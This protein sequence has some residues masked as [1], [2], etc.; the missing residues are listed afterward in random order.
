MGNLATTLNTIDWN[1]LR[2][3]GLKHLQAMAGHIWTDF[4]LHDPGVT[5]LELLCYAIT[6][7]NAR[8]GHEIGALLA[9][10]QTEMAGKRFFSPREILT[11]NPVTV[12]DYRK[13]LIDLPGVK[14]A[15]LLPVSETKPALYYDRD[16]ST[17]LYDYAPGAERIVLKGLYRVLIEKDED[18]TDEEHLKEAVLTRLHAHRNLGEDFVEVKIMDVETISVFSDIEIE[19]N[20]DPNEV[21]GKIY[22]DL[23][24]FISPRVR[25]YSLKRML[26]KGKTIEEIFTG[27]RLENGFIDDAELGTGEKRKELHASDLIRIIMAHP[28]VK[29][30]KNLYMANKPN[31]EFRE[32]QEWA[33]VVDD[34]KALVM[35]AFNGSKLRIFKNGKLCPVDASAVEREVA[36][37]KQEKNRE[38]FDDPAMDLAEPLREAPEGLWT[39]SPL[40]YKLP[41]T[42][43][44][45]ET[46]LPST[47]SEERRAQAKQLRAYLLF[48]EQVLVNYLKQ[49]ASFK[50]LF[51]FRQNR[52]EL[53]KTYFTQLLPEELWK[54]D[55]PEIEEIITNDPTEKLPLSEGAFKRKNRILN[56]LLAQFN[57]KFADYVFFGFKYKMGESLEPGQKERAYLEAKADFLENYPELSYNRNRACNYW[58]PAEELRPVD[59][60]KR[61]IAAKLGIELANGGPIDF[62]TSEEFYIVEH[63]LFRPDASLPL[64][65]LCAEK[66]NEAQQPD[67]YSYRLTFVLPKSAGRF[68]NSRFK[69]L[70][71]T[72][73]ANETPAHLSY[74]V[75]ELNA[76]EM[77]RF[78]STYH[79][80]LREVARHRQEKSA[81]FYLDRKELLELLGIG[82]PGLPLL[83]LDA[84]DVFGDGTRPAPE[85]LIPEWKDLSAN[86]HHA[87][88]ATAPASPR[89]LQPRPEAPGFLRFT[90]KTCLKIDYPL[91]Q[92]DFSL[93]VVFKAGTPPTGGGQQE[94]YY[95]LIAGLGAAGEHFSLGFTNTGK[96]RAEVGGEAVVIEAETGS[97]HLAVLTREQKTGALRLFLDGVVQTSLQTAGRGP[98]A[99]AQVV[100]GPGTVCDLAEVVIVDGVLTGSRKQRLERYLS[101]KWE[102]PLSG[103]S[104]IATPAFHLAADDLASI[105]LDDATRQ[106]SAWRDLSQGRKVVVPQDEKLSPVY[107]G[108]GIGG[109]PALDFNRA[110]LVIPNEAREF[111][112]ADFT[113]GF[114]Y[115]ATAGN[116][117]LLDGRSQTEEVETG[118][119]IGLAADGTLEVK[120]QTGAVQLAADLNEAH[121]AVLTGQS[122]AE[123][124][125]LVTHWLDGKFHAEQ[126]FT[127]PEFFRA[128]P[129]NLTIGQSR[130]G[131][132]AFCGKLG[133]VIIYNQALSDWERQR[134]EEF[135]AEKWQL[136]LTGVEP[137][138]PSVLH[139]DATRLASV[140]DESGRPAEDGEKIEQWLDWGNSDRH[141]V[142]EN[143]YRRPEYVWDGI[144]GLPAIKFSQEQIDEEDYYED[145][146]SIDRVIQNDFTMMVVF[147]PDPQWYAEHDQLDSI[148][149]DTP[150]TDGVPLLDADCSGRYNDF[151]L[152][153]GVTGGKMVLMGGI[154]DR[155]TQD[156]TI[157]SRELALGPPHLATFSREKATGEVKLY[158][159]GLLHAQADLRD[160]VTLNDS[161]SIRI[162]AFNSEGKAFRGLIGEIILFDQ[163][164]TE[165][166]RRRIEEYLSKKWRISLVTLPVDETGLNFHLDATVLAGIAKDEQNKVRQ[167]SDLNPSR[168]FAAVYPE[169]GTPSPI[170]S[171]PL[172]VAEGISGKPALHFNNSLM[173]IAPEPLSSGAFT[174]ALVC[175]AVNAGN[176]VSDWDE[177]G[178]FDH[179]DPDATRNFGLAVTKNNTLRFRLGRQQIETAFAMNVPHIVMI[180]GEPA[181]GKVQLYIDGLLAAEGMG[182]PHF[183]PE[184]IKEFTIG[185]MRKSPDEQGSRGYFYGHLGEVLMFNRVLSERQRQDLEEHL[186]LKWRIDLT[187]VNRIGK[188]VLHLDASRLAT[189]MVD[190]SGRVA[191]WRDVN[192]RSNPALQNKADYRP[193]YQKNAEN[194]LGVIH[195]AGEQYLTL[196][197]V[198]HDDFAVV[199]VY[200][201]EKGA[202][203][204]YMPV[205]VDSFTV[206][207]GDEAGLAELIWTALKS[208]G[209]LDEQGNVLPAFQPDADNFTLGLDSTVV[210]GLQR[211]LAG[212][213]TRV[214]TENQKQQRT[215]P[216]DGLTGIGGVDAELS[217]AIWSHLVKEGYIN[218]NG[219]V[220]RADYTPEGKEEFLRFLAEELVI[221]VVLAESWL[222]GAGIFDGNCPGDRGQPN[223]RD[224][225]ILVGKDGKLLVGIGVPDEQD[226]Q[227][228]QEAS[229][230]QWHI[231]ILTR[232]KETGLVRLYVD[233]A[234]P[235]E[236]RIAHKIS[237]K[238]SKRFTIGAVNTGGN[239]FTGDLGEI[240]VLDQVPAEQELA[241]LRDYLARKWRVVLQAEM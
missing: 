135:L 125:L 194:G 200:R 123:G 213:I 27:P 154:G 24:E 107:D 79:R 134:L 148:D 203:H 185:A 236:K 150:W 117:C 170:D 42:Y 189:V 179:Y 103:V 237:L 187:G 110:G 55:F 156:H 36:R 145:Y 60:L 153:F 35:E 53:L 46:G 2:E 223:K 5:I 77:Q 126:K 47:V 43:G 13:L 232:M 29:E 211:I 91:E 119:A 147:Q 112:Q 159:D 207:T 177:A 164:L 183:V 127:D 132:Q 218:E 231:A 74:N 37:L 130:K 217:E 173:T 139:L 157:K 78:L 122:T 61:L 151:G 197:P 75:L 16:N 191:Q 121:L 143:D 192:G 33:L 67:P 228:A 93:A 17:L 220:L 54:K 208:R 41:A 141:A 184:E 166:Q 111:F 196:N 186:S 90:A 146:L 142:Q 1:G 234:G 64:D 31:P 195:F 11:I 21:M 9:E 172:Y 62:N 133:E 105:V 233:A 206:L 56:H 58:T 34:T 140:L 92:D 129:P 69:E 168:G 193:L 175:Q 160:D 85:S 59:G 137:V 163:V 50:Q 128:C 101:R 115:Q 239:Y 230:G 204:A 82:R 3:E 52:A 222:A 219:R 169:T 49:L 70:V 89:Y 6:D 51:A 209:Y 66:I 144:N 201:A 240:I 215:I 73:I 7:L 152:S 171:P 221:K 32:K 226:Y 136:D 87:V 229:F 199:L 65:F 124:H 57:E 165:G 118:F 97:P 8:L 25:Q 210:D 39:Y 40:T 102:I 28:A 216:V 45:S 95:K 26:Q 14:N 76:G 22:F 225:G 19:A 162:A 96:I 116:G 38:I 181:G 81:Q 149:S 198:V 131:D 176:M 212:E 99:V 83:H 30:V 88:A 188:P 4:G 10:E 113:I 71:Y 15:W 44:V 190:G 241:A 94:E 68:S 108:K 205:A 48:F 109:L 120:G 214:L 20:A 138:A 12:N 202:D 158:V 23:A 98:L 238:D 104:S 80:F 106:V 86:G 100:L 114:V 72:T 155:L 161:R 227:L 235:V 63:I 167:W 84:D 224:F 18:V 178:V 174:I 182:D 180:S